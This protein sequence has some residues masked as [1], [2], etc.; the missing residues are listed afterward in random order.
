MNQQLKT[1]REALSFLDTRFGWSPGEAP[2]ID[3]LREA[4]TQLE[5]MMGP[6]AQQPQ[7][8]PADVHRACPF[9]NEEWVEQAVSEMAIKAAWESTTL[10]RCSHYEAFRSG[11]LWAA[12]QQ[13][14]AV[15]PD[16]VLVPVKPSRRI[17]DAI[18]MARNLKV[19]EIW[20]CAIAAAIAQQ[21]GKN[22]G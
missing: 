7:A 6:V 2:A 1:I 11:V 9:C 21:K 5:A 17:E 16:Y 15:P 22:N 4:A 19:S 14:E 18:A 3:A 12:P 13:A 20:E 10:D 8:R